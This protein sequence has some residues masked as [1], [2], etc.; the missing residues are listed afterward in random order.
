ME[1]NI[2]NNNTDEKDP[3][4]TIEDLKNNIDILIFHEK[5][6]MKLINAL[7]INFTSKGMRGNIPKQLFENNIEVKDL[8]EEEL[9]ALDLGIWDFFQGDEKINKGYISSLY[10][11]N[12]FYSAKLSRIKNMQPTENIVDEWVRLD[13]VQRL[14]SKEYQ[15]YMTPEVLEYLI[16]NRLYEYN[17]DIQRACKVVTTPTGEEILKENYNED[18]L[19]E[20]TERFKKEDI[21]TTQISFTLL[22]EKG[23]DGEFEFKPKY[24]G[25]IG[26]FSFKPVFDMDRPDFFALTINDGAHRLFAKIDAIKEM[27]RRGIEIKQ[28]FSVMIRILTRAEAQQLTVDSFKQNSTDKVY[29]SNLENN[30]ENKFI[31]AYIESSKYYNKRVAKSSH[32]EKM[33][34]MW[35]SFKDMKDVLTKLEKIDFKNEA[36]SIM[37]ANDMG[38]CTR[39]MIDYLLKEYYNDSIEKYSESIFINKNMGIAWFAVSYLLRTYDDTDMVIV[40]DDIYKKQDEIEKILNKKQY[41]EVF[42]YFIDLVNKEGV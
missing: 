36:K 41:K 1:N 3:I 20:L 26:E 11:R 39:K 30:V 17:K 6:N 37:N 21:L 29:R 18:G 28:G 8:N 31:N 38:E 15:L 9:I 12:Y 27:R 42:D 10:P 19:R 34:T 2:I 25:N 23:K 13:G 16:D 22:K 40:A 4:F 32:E 7:A 33:N 24:N 35:A 14:N 5:N